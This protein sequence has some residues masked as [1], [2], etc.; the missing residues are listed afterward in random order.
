MTKQIFLKILKNY[1][2]K[3]VTKFMTNFVN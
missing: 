1:I 2:D 3:C